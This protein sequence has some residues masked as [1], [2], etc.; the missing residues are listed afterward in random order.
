[1][2]TIRQ[3][4]K[5]DY[6]AV[7]DL[8]KEAFASAEHADGTEQDLVERLRKS[9]AFVKELSLVATDG[10]KIVGHILFTKVTLGNTNSLGL[11]PLA[12][13]PSYQKQGI[14]TMLLK[15]GHRIA[16]ELD[17]Q[18]S[19]LLGSEKYY[20]RVGYKRASVFGITA[21]FEA[22]DE[23]FMAI[24]LQ[25]DNDLQVNAELQYAKEFFI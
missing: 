17:F 4:N 5:N 20:P 16:K 11:A 25:E 6:K 19:V 2:I 8:V 14:G 7:Y 21:P 22:P 13:L 1:M 12:I 18:F 23:N 15:E 3:E 24:S 9:D 10:K